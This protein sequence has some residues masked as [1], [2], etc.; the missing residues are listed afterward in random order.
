N[1]CEDE[2]DKFSALGHIAFEICKSG[3]FKY[4]IETIDKVTS[5]VIKSKLLTQLS[6][7]LDDIDFEIFNSEN[8][9]YSIETI[10]KITSKDI[11]S[12]LLRQL[13]QGFAKHNN[14]ET[15][16][17][18]MNK[19]STLKD[20]TNAIKSIVKTL[21]RKDLFEDAEKLINEITGFENRR[22]LICDV[23]DRYIKSEKRDEYLREIMK[24]IDSNKKK[25]IEYEPLYFNK[26][27]TYLIKDG[28]K[29]FADDNL[30]LNGHNA[31]KDV[32]NI[33][34]INELMVQNENLK[35]LK[36]VQEIDD[37]NKGYAL[38]H[39][40]FELVKQKKI[41]EAI[42]VADGIESNY[43]KCLAYL[44]IAENMNNL[45]K[46]AKANKFVNKV[47]EFSSKIEDEGFRSKVLSDISKVLTKLDNLNLA[48]QI[49][50]SISDEND[51]YRALS[52]ISK[53]LVKQ[54]QFNKA[55]EIIKK[56]TTDADNDYEFIVKSLV[57]ND[58]LDLAY[59]TAILIEEKILKSDL[60]KEISIGYAKKLDI[61]QA[62]SL[63]DEIPSNVSTCSALIS[64]SDIIS[65]N[66]NNSQAEKIYSN[67][68]SQIYEYNESDYLGSKSTQEIAINLVK[69]NKLSLALKVVEDI[70]NPIVKSEVLAEIVKELYKAGKEKNI[71]TLLERA[72]EIAYSI[73]D[74][75]LKSS[76][77]ER[78]SNAFITINEPDRAKELLVDVSTRFDK[79]SILESIV[80]IYLDNDNYKDVFDI[81]NMFDDVSL[82]S[83]KVMEIID[84]GYD[85]LG[86]IFFIN[87]IDQRLK[88]SEVR[89]NAYSSLI[90]KVGSQPDKICKSIPQILEHVYGSVNLISEALYIWSIHERFWNEDRNKAII[91]LKKLNTVIELSD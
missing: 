2:I 5:E 73:D 32:W 58:M 29:E 89:S 33:N 11:K 45:G 90:K 51:K 47:I 74:E 57:E 50:D 63:C 66:G 43:S 30:M 60:L 10:D 70:R 25:S 16:V 71:K 79:Y 7:A 76:A 56:I 46:I 49:S 44:K 81:I 64:I 1:M 85:N 39:I 67:A 55:L 72:L 26:I 23:A 77:L 31:K 65:N 84:K 87:I 42:D 86:L 52:A 41:I 24:T 48:I 37:I 12:D 88:N 59:D 20:K 61:Q 82:A 9:E 18:L 17:E 4:A 69:V 36:L 53:E 68:I 34:I 78:I 3:N 83:K 62:I 38:R 80:D 19:I 8:F 13:S 22:I 27:S 6:Y 28:K 35:A 21:V 15:A 14:I 91:I 75:S 54:G 40:C